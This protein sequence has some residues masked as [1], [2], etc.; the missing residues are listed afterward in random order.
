MKKLHL[1]L[2]ALFTVYFAPAQQTGKAK[3]ILDQVSKKTQSYSS[4]SADFK[5]SMINSEQNI[6]EGY[7]GTIILKGDKYNVFINDLGA[8][9]VSDGKTVWSY[10][11][12]ANEVTISSVDS[13]NQDL[14][15]PAKIFTIYQ[16]GFTYNYVGEKTEDGT[17]V[18]Q[19]DLIPQTD[20]Y[21]FK[22]ISMEINKTTMMIYSASFFD[23][24]GTQFKIDVEKVVT[25]KPV[26]D[27]M[28]VFNTS[29]YKDIEII[30]YRK[31]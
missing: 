20:K 7:T 26:A 21:D 25:D 6:D 13:E 24:G 12:D 16:N 27:S 22:K 4:I 5:Y 28:F 18:Y 11:T 17:P 30:D 1:I 8:R 3:E 14:F 19:I 15:D 2:I 9:M 10:M 23:K 29:K 31:P